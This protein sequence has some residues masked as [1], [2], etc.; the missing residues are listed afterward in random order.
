MV[1]QINT[2]QHST[3][4][5]GQSHATAKR[6]TQY[7]LGLCV[8]F[9]VSAV[10]FCPVTQA[11]LANVLPPIISVLKLSGLTFSVEGIAYLAFLGLLVI[12]LNIRT[13]YQG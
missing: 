1:K 7:F 2:L 11:A 8:L 10:S 13:K 9:I 3:K 4:S 12:G 6:Y 5:Q